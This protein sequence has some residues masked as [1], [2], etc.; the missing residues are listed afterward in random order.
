MTCANGKWNKQVSCEPVDCGMP[1]KYHVH[2]ANFLFPEGTTYGK[3]ITFQC[4][5]PAQLI[6]SNNT[7]TCLEDGLWSFPEALCEL[8]CP[9]PPPVPNAVL[10]TKRCSEIG[11]KV[12]TLCKYKCKPGYHVTGKPKRRAFKRQCTEDGSWLEGACEPVTCDPPPSIFHG[13][14]HCSDGFRFDSVCRLNCSEAGA[15]GGSA[16]TVRMPHA[17]CLQVCPSP[18]LCLCMF[19]L[20]VQMVLRPILLCCV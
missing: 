19:L 12:G 16:H 10:Q 20:C 2:P 15:A 7:L 4:R 3:R 11:L 1:D 8:R 18:S 13:S 5:E 6:G 9:A 17:P 14:Y